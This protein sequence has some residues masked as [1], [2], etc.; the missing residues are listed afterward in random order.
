MDSGAQRDPPA[1][2]VH[3]D[4]GAQPEA[5]DSGAPTGGAGTTEDVGASHKSAGM[6]VGTP[7]YPSGILVMH[8][9]HDPMISMS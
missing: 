8:T 3:L 1:P 9:T 5:P 6:D 4:T 7:D 2:D